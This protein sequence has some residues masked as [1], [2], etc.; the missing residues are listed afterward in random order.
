MRTTVAA[1]LATAALVLTPPLSAEDSPWFVTIPLTTI[2]PV[3]RNETQRLFDGGTIQTDG[4]AQMTFSF[5]GEFKEGV[6]QSGRIGALLV[7]DDSRVLQLLRAEGQIIFA[8]EV[9]FQVKPNQGTIFVS[10]QQ[11]ERIAFPRYRVF[12]YNETGSTA[13]VSLSVYRSK[14]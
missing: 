12:F 7:P 6:P 1:L 8:V 9:K 13:A 2:T 3:A 5:A 11:T 14:C 4:F 10:D